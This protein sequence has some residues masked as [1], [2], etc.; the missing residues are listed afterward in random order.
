MEKF[1]TL[2]WVMAAHICNTRGGD[3]HTVNTGEFYG[4]LHFHKAIKNESTQ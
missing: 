3:S 4:K 2:S 1:S